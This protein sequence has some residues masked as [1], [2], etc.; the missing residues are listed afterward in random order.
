MFANSH[1]LFSSKSW[2]WGCYKTLYTWAMIPYFGCIISWMVSVEA[3]AK[4]AQMLRALLFI[5]CIASVPSSMINTEAATV[6][7]LVSVA[8]WSQSTLVKSFVASWT[9]IASMS[10]TLSSMLPWCYLNKFEA[11]WIFCSRVIFSESLGA[12]IKALRMSSSL[13][14]SDS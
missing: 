3:I 13:T 8:T 9:L 5:V 1:R 4:F 7:M 10:A 2:V 12:N 14:W 11:Y 6:N